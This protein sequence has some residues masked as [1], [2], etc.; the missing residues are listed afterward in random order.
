MGRIA[1]AIQSI[2]LV[3]DARNAAALSA[4]APRFAY[5]F[6]KRF[7]DLAAPKA[8]RLPIH[9]GIQALPGSLWSCHDIYGR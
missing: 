2:F 9:R 6:R 3:I 7:F 1:R 8:A 5:R 4:F